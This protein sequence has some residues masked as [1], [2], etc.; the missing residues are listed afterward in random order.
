VTGAPRV[1]VTRPRAQASDLV[2]ALEAWGARPVL[3]PTVE[4]RAPADS[5]PI[6]R[7]VV[8]LRDYHW[9]VL[10]SANAVAAV[11]DRLGA[12]PGAGS[13]PRIAA[14]GPAT[15]AEIRSRG[16]RVDFVPSEY[17]GTQLGRELPDVEGRTILLPQGDQAGSE[18]LDAL[19]GRGA[20]VEVVEAYR[21]APP[22]HPDPRELAD[23]AMGVDAAVFTSGSAVRH[24][25]GLLGDDAT[26][27]ALRGA[28]IA[29]IGPVTGGVARAL[30]LEVHV[31]PAEHTIPAVVGAL[32]ARLAT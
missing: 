9:L 16:A 14:L 8:R 5:A 1:L 20:R 12:A 22:E 23:L 26:R 24:L 27:M 30:G 7:A 11:F 17:L 31:E 28:V 18:L 3:F 25:F 6:E 19:S 2:R 10:T 21:T 32:Q 29:C 13:G 15:A 4:I